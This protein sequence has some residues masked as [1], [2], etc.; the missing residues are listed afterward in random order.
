MTSGSTGMD[1]EQ[2]LAELWASLDARLISDH[3]SG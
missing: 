3:P 1:W 2:R